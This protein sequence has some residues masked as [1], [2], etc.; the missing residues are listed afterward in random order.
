[1][2]LFESLTVFFTAIAFLAGLAL[3]IADRQARRQPVRQESGAWRR[4][5]R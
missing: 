2:L 5:R 1:M 4:P 3:V